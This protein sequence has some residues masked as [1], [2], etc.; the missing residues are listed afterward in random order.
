MSQR[1][2]PARLG[3][4]LGHS[5]EDVSLLQIFLQRFGYLRLPEVAEDFAALRALAKPPTAERGVFDAATGAA[6]LK[7]QEFF[8]LPRTGVLDQQTIEEMRLPRCGVPDLP[9]E[10]HAEYAIQGNKWSKSTLTYGF[11]EFTPDLLPAVIQAAVAQAFSLWSAVVSLRFVEVP[12]GSG[13]DIVIRFV[14]GDHGDG[15]PFDG[16][17]S[18]LAH[19]FYPP[20]NGGAIAGDAHFDEAE[21]WTVR[22]HAKIT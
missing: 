20:P 7:Y 6:L 4:S 1:K 13:P 11:S 18:V 10:A 19:A 3:L 16:P 22:A 15:S 14:S 5:G 12:V 8:G 2:L 21:T 17:G 9:S